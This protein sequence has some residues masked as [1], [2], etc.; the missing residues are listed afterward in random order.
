M[1]LIGWLMFLLVLA[2]KLMSLQMRRLLSWS[3]ESVL[4]KT[5][6]ASALPGKAMNPRTGVRPVEVVGGDTAAKS[7]CNREECPD[8]QPFK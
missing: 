7:N 2:P 8:E 6:R 3:D 5:D 4:L 1:A